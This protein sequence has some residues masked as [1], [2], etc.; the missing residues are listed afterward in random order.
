VSGPP[1]TK[2][3]RATAR[4]AHVAS[5]AG[6]FDAVALAAA[7]AERLDA[8]LAD[9]E[10]DADRVHARAAEAD[11][12]VEAAADAGAADVVRVPKA[13]AGGN[14]RRWVPIGP[15][16]IRAESGRTFKRSTGRVRDIQVSNDGKRAYAATAK[17]GLWYTGDA[18]QLWLPVGGWVERPRTAG[19]V[20]N[21]QA[22][23][24]L[25][26][27]FGLTAADDYVMVGT[28]ELQGFSRPPIRPALGGIGVLAG[29]HPATVALGAGGDP[30]EPESGLAQFEGRGV[31]RLVRDPAATAGR[32]TGAG[33]DRVL[34][35]TNDGLF[36]GTRRTAPAPHNGEFTWAQLSALGT[37]MGLAPGTQ[38][39]VTDALWF[40][41][42]AQADGR[43]V[44]AVAR[45]LETATADAPEGSGVAYSDDRGVSW[46]WVDGLDPTV[47]AA[48]KAMGRM[49]LANPE[50][51]RVY[52]LGERKH[53]T[54]PPVTDIQSLWRI[55]AM[56]AASPVAQ[57]VSGM[58]TELWRRGSTGRN[59]RDYDQAI[60]VDVVAGVDRVYLAGNTRWVDGWV[61]S[62]WCFDVTMP[63]RTLTP[64]PGISR[65]GAPELPPPPL[66]GGDDATVPGF[67]GN[68][69]HPDVHCVRVAGPAGL[70][71][72]VWVSTDGGIY[73]STRAGRVNTFAARST[74]IS[75]VEVQFH[76][77]HP[78][79]SHFGAIGTQDNGRH[80]RV[81]DVVWED[82]TSGDGGGVTI[83]PYASQF[84]VSQFN[85]A[86]WTATP[87]VGFV[88]PLDQGA[89]AGARDRESGLSSFYSG[90]ATAKLPPATGRLAI[91]TNRVWLSDDLGSGVDNTWKVLPFG[92]AGPAT[93]P[94]VGGLDPVAKQGDGVPGGAPLAPV[95]AGVGP[96][97]EVV[98]TKWAGPRKLLVVFS[99]GVV[100]WTQDPMTSNWSARVL[101]AFGNPA[102]V[103]P[104]T[105]PPNLATTMISD[106]APIPGTDDFYLLT[107][108]NPTAAAD[109]TCYHFRDADNTYRKTGLRAQLGPLD[110]AYAVTVDP[111]A[112]AT[113]YVGTVTGVWRGVRGAGPPAAGLPWP[114]TW[115]ADVNGLP[116]AAVQDLDFWTVDPLVAGPPRLLRASLQSRGVWELDVSAAAEPQRT[117]LRAH[118][119]DDRRILPTS[120]KNP[121]LEPAAPNVVEWASP[122]IVVR[123]RPSPATAPTWR[124]GA[125]TLH[126]F[127][128]LPYQLWTFQTAFRWL[129]PSVPAD[130]RWGKAFGDL[131]EL[132]RSTAAAFAPV[133]RRINQ[134]LWDAVV[135]TTRVNAAGVVNA[136]PGDPLAVYRPPWQTPAAMN[137]VPTE[138]DLIDNVV[139]VNQAP[140][141]LQTLYKEPSVVD[142]LL[143]HR[144]IR[145]LPMGDPYAVLLWREDASQAALLALDVAAL[146][147]YAAAV[148][149]GNPLPATPGWTRVLNGPSAKH[150]LAL[151]QL[152]A[153]MPRAVSIDVDFTAVPDGHFVL[154]VAFTGSSVDAM[155]LAPVGLPATPTIGDLVRRWPYA[156][157]RL[158]TVTARP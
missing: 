133:E 112:P 38:P 47:A 65:T 149:A 154:L 104:V 57:L 113:V 85:Y 94:R 16:V 1:T 68:D 122:D 147:A 114:H 87:D 71:R 118:A 102:L 2:R 20:L 123:P 130:G 35:A 32:A 18:G 127:N 78:T 46:H 76:A 151:V 150:P 49:S 81:G 100:R 36:L 80:V 53:R 93:N 126:E 54:P 12:D 108:G 120:M 40:S 13:F 109:D 17:G 86:G 116:Q 9:V 60:A 103:P 21:G 70:G 90:A 89:G 39:I 125:G 92:A 4:A 132:H 22:C 73:V 143:H 27:S 51:D 52:V 59:Q 64:A 82:V 121:R 42:L 95:V 152:D 110:P 37:F 141:G 99:R 140:D 25:L 153:R 105:G 106:I 8:E 129:Y 146:Q 138:I 43:M 72:H 96:L 69:L 3:G 11:A 137:A 115:T 157:A 101:V 63:A 79:S 117:Y 128:V 135:G 97:G 98:T 15:S 56:N 144:D 7:M 111:G 34:A 119:A 48:D 155:S 28:G 41:R 124:L 31:F 77:A 5:R 139:P 131:V 29:A 83:H 88:D 44:V 26:V 19:G 156:A 45:G 158:I 61:A 67:I 10:V 136:A 62:L 74:G 33:L 66:K 50:A 23:G 84:I 14:A 134:A 142:V 148:A 58:P 55:A 91:G 6:E 107:T 24:C 75:A 145:P 30:W